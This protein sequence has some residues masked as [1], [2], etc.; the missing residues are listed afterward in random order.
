MHLPPMLLPRDACGKIH[1]SIGE[2]HSAAFLAMWPSIVPPSENTVTQLEYR[3]LSGSLTKIIPSPCLTLMS[4]R[5]DNKLVQG[6]YRLPFS[7][8]VRRRTCTEVNVSGIAHVAINVTE[9]QDGRQKVALRLLR[10]VS[11]ELALDPCL[12]P[13]L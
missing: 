4:D 6:D 2:S 1:K 10:P 13:P 11:P 12:S 5:S 8:L 3:G 7:E 9:Q